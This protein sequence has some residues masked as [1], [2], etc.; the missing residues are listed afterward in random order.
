M[1]GLSRALHEQVSFNKKG[2]T[3]LDWVTYPILRFKDAPKV[4]IHGLTRTDVPDPAW[5]RL[6]DD[7][8]GRARPV[9]GSGGDR[10]RVLRRH[11]C[12]HP[13]GADDAGP[14][15]R[16]AEGSRQVAERNRS[17]KRGPRIGPSPLL[18]S[19]LLAGWR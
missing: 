5:P 1:Q 13:R 7:R 2:V 11:G 16:G 18:V 19:R 6:A 3:S 17:K 15:P 14:R 4:H 10:Q 8:L 9:A 12:S